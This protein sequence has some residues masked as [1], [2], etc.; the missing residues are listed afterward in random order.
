MFLR[1]V[2][3]YIRSPSGPDERYSRYRLWRAS[4]PSNWLKGVGQSGRGA[5]DLSL[6]RMQT[7][8]REET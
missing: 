7:E 5:L 8:Q 3:R 2:G 6:Q 1:L 4:D